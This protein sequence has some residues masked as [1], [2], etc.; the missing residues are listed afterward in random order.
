MASRARLPIPTPASPSLV[1]A[2]SAACAETVGIGR[3]VPAVFAV[4]RLAHFRIPRALAQYANL[5]RDPILRALEAKCRR[6]GLAASFAVLPL[7]L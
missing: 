4:G 3:G 6:F 5:V 7:D 1:V 2:A